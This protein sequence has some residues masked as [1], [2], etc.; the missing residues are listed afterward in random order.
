MSGFYVKTREAS[1]SAWRYFTADGGTT[2]LR[3]RAATFSLENAKALVRDVLL[4]ND[5]FLAKPVR[6]S[7][8]KAVRMIACTFRNRARAYQHAIFTGINKIIIPDGLASEDKFVH[9]KTHYL[10]SLENHP[11]S[12]L[13]EK[14]VRVDDKLYLPDGRVCTLAK[15]SA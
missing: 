8:G 15:G 7:T 14:I 3:I 11:D 9:S 2:N 4:E 5:G 13:P 12:Y 10:A 6:A 1:A